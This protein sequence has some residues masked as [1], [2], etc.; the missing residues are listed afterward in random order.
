MSSGRPPAIFALLTSKKHHQILWK[1]FVFLIWSNHRYAL[2]GSPQRQQNI[3]HLYKYKNISHCL[4]PECLESPGWKVL[5]SHDPPQRVSVEERKYLR[6]SK[7][8]F[9]SSFCPLFFFPLDSQARVKNFN[10][11]A[12]IFSTGAFWITLRSQIFLHISSNMKG[13]LHSHIAR[14]IWRFIF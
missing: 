10:L 2:Q 9:T 13:I 14:L 12:N 1:F 7:S 3:Y 4:I 6:P 8:Q 11:I 5:F